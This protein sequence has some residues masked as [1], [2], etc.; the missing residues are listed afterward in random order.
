MTC[1]HHY[2][3]NSGLLDTITSL[4]RTGYYYGDITV[5]EAESILRDEPNGAFIV[6][7]SSDSTS[8]TDL[9]TI[10]FKIQN[11]FGSVRVDYAKGYF[12]LSLQDPGLPLFHTLM[13]LV[14]Y[15][16]HRSCV[17]K[18]PVCVLTGHQQNH[19]VHLYLT[20]PVS[21]HRRMHSLMFSCRDAI[22]RFVTRDRLDKLGLPKRLV[23]FYISQNPY[24]DEQ[25]F[26]PKPT[27]DLGT[28]AD[29]DMQS[30][31]SRNSLQL[32]T[33]GDGQGYPYH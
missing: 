23:E 18:L 15:C 6:R 5:D 12:S 13:D 30:T 11:R 31:G 10:T 28:S 7:D 32:N 20:K 9:F 3:R 14:S 1:C 29:L 22:H 16:Q 25:L 4:P 27:E 33:G 2:H 17:Q 21:R 26:P 8:F 24:F 19:D